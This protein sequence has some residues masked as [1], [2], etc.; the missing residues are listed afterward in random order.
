MALRAA[1]TGLT[2]PALCALAVEVWSAGLEGA[3]R[4]P[5]GWVQPSHLRRCEEFLDRFTLRGRCPGDELREHLTAAP[6]RALAWAR[7][8]MDVPVARSARDRR[9]ADR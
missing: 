1:R 8:P 6:S 4:L 2:H 9:G 3:R 7:E 5:T